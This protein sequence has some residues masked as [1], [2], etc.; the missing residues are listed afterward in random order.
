[1]HRLPFYV[2]RQTGYI[3]Q[4]PN[5]IM[6]R[7]KSTAAADLKRPIPAGIRMIV[8]QHTIPMAKSMHAMGNLTQVQMSAPRSSPVILKPI[9]KINPKTQRR[10][11]NVIM[12]YISLQTFY[13]IK[14]LRTPCGELS[15]D[16]QI[17]Y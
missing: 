4:P 14:A 12:V 9:P 15:P 6:Q 11:N 7:G 1:M 5:Y 3:V 8:Q 17:P 13:E 2:K 16:M 10:I